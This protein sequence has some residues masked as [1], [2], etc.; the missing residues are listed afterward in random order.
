MSTLLVTGGAGFIGSRFIDWVYRTTKHDIVC[1]DKLTYAAD[2][3]R[4]ADDIWESERFTFLETDIQ[5]LAL[6]DVPTFHYLINFAA[7]SHVDNSIADGS[8]FI[9]SNILGVM[10]LLELVKERGLQGFE[11]YVQISTDE[12]YGDFEDAV[13]GAVETDPL[14]PSSYYSASK[15]SAD[16]LVIAAGRTFNI[17]YLITRSCNNFGLDQHP[18]KLIP[19]IIECLEKGEEVPVY[20]DGKQVRE[21]IHVEDNVRLI[22]LLMRTEEDADIVNIGSGFE[23]TNLEVIQKI[24]KAMGVTPTLK[25]VADRLGHDRRYSLDCS[26]L[27]R[28]VSTDWAFYCLEGTLEDWY[29]KNR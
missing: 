15:A 28:R 22:Y 19:T 7:E 16:M 4:I 5:D 1:V 10:N 17:P 9:Q 26:K 25:Y 8:P 21:W 12:V 11:K 29:D 3:K 20:G 2:K 6:E 27:Q 24:G 18:E 13:K 14:H 23:Y